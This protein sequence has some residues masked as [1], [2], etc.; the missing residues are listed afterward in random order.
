MQ[1]LVVGVNHRTA[2]IEIR[3]RMA[4]PGELAVQ[5]ARAL[6]G[7]GSVSEAMAVSTCNRVELYLA[8]DRAWEAESSVCAQIAERAGLSRAQL[9]EHLYVHHD[10]DAVRHIF[11]VASSL[12]SMVV[13]EPQILGQIKQSYREACAIDAIGQ[14]LDRC[15]RQ[16]FS[17][18]KRVRN[19][20]GIAENAVSLAYVA[21]ELARQIFGKL[22]HKRG[23]LLGAGQMSALA[24][25]HLRAQG[26][27]LVITN[28][29]MARAEEL[30]QELDGVARPLET[31]PSLLTDTDIVISSTSA[32][33]WV[34]TFETMQGIMRAR[35]N[36]PLFLID[37]AVPRDIE[38]RVNTIDNVYLYDVD[39]LERVIEQNRAQRQRAADEAGRIVDAEAMRFVRRMRRQD[40]VPTIVALRDRFHTLAEAQLADFERQ[41]PDLDLAQRQ[42]VQAMT[43]R[44][45]NKLLHTPMVN[46]KRASEKGDPGPMVDALDEL[47][48]LSDA[49][50][51]TTA[52][53][54][55]QTAA[56]PAPETP[57]R[58]VLKAT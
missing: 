57:P 16:A 26:A 6:L 12:D 52:T 7:H 36:R 47:F 8:A 56:D 34:L 50:P 4:L 38:P 58:P 51:E 46:L 23:L 22:A 13:G 55:R 54:R 30:A 40:V 11:R 35:R 29:S 27:D 24:A 31:L 10:L 42:A 15:L 44:L 39:D 3:E 48:E 41:N 19:E 1:L 33:G 53:S 43:R 21:V 18:A 9:A 37:L 32:T 28:R 25:R 49:N 14:H 2:P 17:V 5:A 45:V 20:T